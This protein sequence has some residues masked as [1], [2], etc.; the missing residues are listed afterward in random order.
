MIPNELIRFAEKIKIDAIKGCWNWIAYTDKDGYGKFWYGNRN[1]VA[2][3]FSYEFYKEPLGDNQTDHLC[4]N[5]SCVNPDHLESVTLIENLRRRKLRNITHCIRDHEYTE[6]NTLWHKNRKT[7][8]S[9]RKCKTCLSMHNSLNAQAKNPNYVPRPYRRLH[10]VD[11][12]AFE[13]LYVD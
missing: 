2:S 12:A 4:K 10:N 1:V 6:E 5:T 11:D 9:T 7:G 8:K 3:R 13:K